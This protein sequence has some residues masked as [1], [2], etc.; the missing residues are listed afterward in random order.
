MGWPLTSLADA[1]HCRLA[2]AKM[3]AARQVP[4]FGDGDACLW[5]RTPPESE[6]AKLR[7][8]HTTST[9]AADGP[10]L[11]LVPDLQPRRAHGVDPCEQAVAMTYI[12]RYGM[13]K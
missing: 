10:A 12:L 5:P 8:G 6:P 11:H 9:I 7:A 2:K 1:S 4:A 13:R 3:A